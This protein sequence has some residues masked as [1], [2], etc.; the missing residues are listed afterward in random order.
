MPKWTKERKIE[1]SEKMKEM[2]G[3]KKTRNIL[4][5]VY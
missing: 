3:N 5:G 2:A 1:F 4:S